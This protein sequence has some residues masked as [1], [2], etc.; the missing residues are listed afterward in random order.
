M[1]KRNWSYIFFL[2]TSHHPKERLNRT[3]RVG[4]RGKNVYFCSRC[5]G[6]AFGILAVFAGFIFGFRF[7]LQLYLPLISILPLVAVADW[8][9]QSAKLRESKNWIRLASG[10]L[11]GGSEGLSFLLLFNGFFLLFF[12][13]FGV[14]SIYAVS[15]YLIAV[16]TKCL[17]RYL[18]EMSLF[19]TGNEST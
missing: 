3:F 8:F 6:V 15:V 1:A 4:F 2:L 11:L 17:N 18:D 14:A 19:Q 5:T 9:S 16:K 7:P 12:V 13:V 10:F